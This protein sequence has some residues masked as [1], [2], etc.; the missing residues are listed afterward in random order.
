MSRHLLPK[1]IAGVVLVAGVLTGCAPAA[2]KAETSSTS[3]SAEAR[4][5][6][7]STVAP[8]GESRSGAFEGLNG[9]KVAGTA[10]VSG[11]TVDLSG[12][13]SDEGPDL[14]LYLTNGTDEKAVSAGVELGAVSYDTKTQSFDVADAADYS[15][16]VVHCDKAKAVFGAA[17]LS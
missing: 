1:A 16:V 14:H 13:S 2:D 7:P 9:K 3:S 17:K 6:A 10:T 15:Y 8:S 5:T 11:A 4:T 12:F